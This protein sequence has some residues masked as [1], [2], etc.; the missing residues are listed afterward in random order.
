MQPQLDKNNCIKK[1]KSSLLLFLYFLPNLI[2]LKSYTSGY[3]FNSL[4]RFPIQNYEASYTLEFTTSAAAYY[5]FLTLEN[6]RGNTP[7]L[8]EGFYI[9]YINSRSLIVCYNAYDKISECIV[10]GTKDMTIIGGSRGY[11]L[12]GQISFKAFEQ[13]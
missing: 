6:L 10:F 12:N 1:K 8:Q 3:N 7:P 5:N 9:S 4:L 13:N 11:S 2:D